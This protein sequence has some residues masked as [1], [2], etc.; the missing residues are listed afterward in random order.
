MPIVTAKIQ[1]QGASQSVQLPD[2]F[3]FDVDEV[4]IFRRGKEVVLREK[5]SSLS[6]AF[7]LLASMP[8][9]FFAK[10][11]QDPPPEVREML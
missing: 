6:E 11:R 4:E 2:G 8:K 3:Q 9:D 1:R 10:E 7:E 5:P